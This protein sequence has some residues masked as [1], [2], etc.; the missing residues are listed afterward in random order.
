MDTDIILVSILV[1]ILVFILVII[2]VFILVSPF[3]VVQNW[4]NY[5]EEIFLLIFKC[6]TCLQ[7]L[8]LSCL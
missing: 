3:L 2:L 1:F 6:E 7:N 8:S 5:L 4:E